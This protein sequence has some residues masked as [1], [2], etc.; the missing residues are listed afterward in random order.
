MLL[1]E[2]TWNSRIDLRYPVKEIAELKSLLE[3]QEQRWG[4]DH[5]KVVGCLEALADF[6]QM[7]GKYAEAEPYYWQILEK[8]HKQFGANDLR[9]ADTIYDLACLH[10]K[11]ENWDECERLY[12]WTCDIRCRL[13]PPGDS[14]LDDAASKARDIAQRQGHQ[15]DLVIDH[16]HDAKPVVPQFRFDWEYYFDKSRILIDE[17]YYDFAEL[18]LVCL[19]ETAESFDP[20]SRAE[21]ESLHWLARV[22]FKQTKLAESLISF[23]RALAL[24]EQ[25]SGISSVETALCLEDMADLRC[26]LGEAAEAEFLYNWAL[27]IFES[28]GSQPDA[29]D[30]L[31]IKLASLDELCRKHEENDKAEYEQSDF[32]PSPI[33][34]ADSGLKHQASGSKLSLVSSEGAELDNEKTSLG[35]TDLVAHFLWSSWVDAGRVALN[36]GDLVGAEVMLARGLDKANEFGCQDPRLWQTLCEMGQLHLKQAKFVK[37]VSMFNTAQQYCEKTL[38]PAHTRNAKYWEELGKVYENQGDTAQA[39]SCFDK[40]VTIMVKANRPLVEYGTYLKKLER[41]H[42]K[43]PAGFYD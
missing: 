25:L 11:Q 3:W 22:Q 1:R 24:Y 42:E 5:P 7:K 21:A 36:K 23:E 28:R 41:L 15:L 18:L 26:K 38:G 8:K 4:A 19:V 14:I 37:A 12:K 33:V 30:A 35:E 43:P 27:Q 2:S 39:L 29:V 6:L 40:L 16:N 9:V 10:E 13:V 17:G 32:G 31:K 34:G 20:R